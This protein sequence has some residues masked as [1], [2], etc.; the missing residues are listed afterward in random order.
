MWSEAFAS[1]REHVQ[2]DVVGKLSA[3]GNAGKADRI[4]GG[5]PIAFKDL[6][7]DDLDGL[8]GLLS[9]GVRRGA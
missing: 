5:G 6:I 7:N 8:A 4:S 2:I 3:V 1:T 9:R